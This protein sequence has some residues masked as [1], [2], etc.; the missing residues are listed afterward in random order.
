MAESKNVLI[1]RI[2]ISLIKT[3]E[4]IVPYFHVEIC[5]DPDD[6]KFLKCVKVSHAFYI[7]S[8]D[9]DLLVIEKFQ[10]I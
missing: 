9:K 7:V 3:M 5:C 4:I 8:W 10:N 1:R 2:L 6:S